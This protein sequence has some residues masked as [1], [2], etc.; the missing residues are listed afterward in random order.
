SCGDDGGSAGEGS[1]DPGASESTVGEPQRGGRLVLGMYAEPRSLDP[2]QASGAGTGGGTE[3]MALYDTIMRWNP[4]TND[5]EPRTAESLTPNDD[6]TSWELKLRSGIRFRDGTPY[7]AEA[8]KLSIERHRS[9]SGAS[10]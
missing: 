7:D 5:Y 10:R 1:V 6:Y 3:M 8:V 9:A 2:V 4:D